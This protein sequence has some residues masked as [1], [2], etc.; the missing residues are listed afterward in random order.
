MSE[1]SIRLQYLFAKYI[2]HSCTPAELQEFW[3]LMN[4]LDELDII[5]EDI[6]DLWRKNNHTPYK[7]TDV[8]WEQVYA[9]IM[10][11]ARLTEVDYHSL[12][13][14][15]YKMRRYIPAAAVLLGIVLITVFW[16]VKNDTKTGLKKSDTPV[17][18]QPDASPAAEGAVLTLADGSVLLLDSAGSGVIAQQGAVKV[19]QQNGQLNYT[20]QE[21]VTVAQL[22]NTLSTSKGQQSPALVLAD[23]TKVWLNAASSIKFPVTFKGNLREVEMTGEAYFEVAH[24]PQKP[25]RV[26]VA[27]KEVEVLGTTFN[28]NAYADENSIKT[29]LLEGK[30]RLGNIQLSPGQ[31]AVVNSRGAINLIPQVNLQHETAW[32]NGFFAFSNAGLPEVM[33]E[34]S[35]WYNVEVEYTGAI[36]QRAFEG[37]IQRNLML[38]QVLKILDLQQVHYKMEHQKIKIMP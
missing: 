24:N 1:N 13:R 11:K 3:Q 7:A 37:K 33:R 32:R 18:V 35:R 28:I 25:F 4:G 36:P 17:T 19:Q 2:Q 26:H 9:G 21:A 34:L 5:T 23:G 27:G 38:S 31:Q 15:K 6:K 12:V 29:T 30:V 20:G 22:M 16:F 14:K 10:A 8:G